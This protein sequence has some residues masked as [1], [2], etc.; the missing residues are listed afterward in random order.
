MPA[1]SGVLCPQLHRLVSLIARR[2]IYECRSLVESLR[3]RAARFYYVAS[4]SRV[5][6]RL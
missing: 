2:I 1:V 3:L 4:R 5:L 6:W